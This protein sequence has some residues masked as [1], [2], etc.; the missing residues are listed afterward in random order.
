MGSLPCILGV[1]FEILTVIFAKTLASDL[2]SNSH[3]ALKI[4]TVDLL[5][6]EDAV[7]E[8]VVAVVEVE[9]MTFSGL[10]QVELILV[11]FS[12]AVEV[13]LSW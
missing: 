9:R 6:G 2:C 1:S 12:G 10:C 5:T 13:S 7:V 3:F 11:S 8:T 4:G